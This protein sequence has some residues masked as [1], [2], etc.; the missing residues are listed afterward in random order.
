[1]KRLIVSF[2]L[3]AHTL[4]I[5]A[6]VE[7]GQEKISAKV[8]DNMLIVTFHIPDGYHQV[9]EKALFFLEVSPV[10]GLQ[11]G[12][13]T[14]PDTFIK[15]TY[16]NEYRGETDLKK[17]IFLDKKP[18]A[19]KIKLTA[20]YQLCNNSGTCFM[21]QEM[22]LD[23]QV[24][25]SDLKNNP[26]TATPKNIAV[27]K[28]I[29]SVVKDQSETAGNTEDIGEIMPQYGLMYILLLAFAGGLI[30]NLMPCV[31][32]VLSIKMLN[33]IDHA[34]SDRKTIIKSSMIYT[35]G[36]LLSFLVLALLVIFFKASGEAVGW[37]FQFQNIYFVFF[38]FIIIWAFALSLFELFIIN[39]PGMQA[40]VKASSLHGCLG[41]FMS[42]IFAVVLATPCTAP[43]LGTAVGFAFKQPP[44]TIIIIMLAVGLGLAFPFILLGFFPSIMKIIP[45]PGNWMNA[46]RITMG[47]LLIATAVFL[48]KTL[49][50]IASPKQFFN[51]IWFTLIFSFALWIF[52]SFA[53]PQFSKR[54]QWGG[55][56]ISLLITI[57]AGFYLLN[58]SQ[59][60]GNTNDG[61]S[62]TQR[63]PSKGDWKTFSPELL[64]K[65]RKEGKTVFIDFSAE[66][67]MTCKSN[68]AIVL[69]S[70]SVKKA[71]AEH[72]V[73]ILYG[74]FTKKNPIILEWLKKYNK[75]GVPLYLLFK[76]G[77]DKAIVF[78]EIITRNMV[79]NALSK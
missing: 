71:F 21:P 52:G 33:I 70:K 73:E 36:V 48:L 78:P 39:I 10:K 60:N 44:L 34:H 57:F 62:I 9:T 68:E 12:P 2:L 59:D 42:G 20:H 27:E 56:I 46:F 64:A 16:C 26:Q 32:P 76:P 22:I 23:V 11:F 35:L 40:A 65:L 79:L 55:T 14:Y 50:F 43:M 1:M 17:E 51:I 5:Y 13:T 54:K 25:P 75:V 4:L 72:K 63:S 3:F 37:G 7:P 19:D 74:D 38:L 47:F 28:K 49:Y 66:W 45:K 15:G 30:L 69:K 24:S 31:L 67:C 58:F 6:S 18:T 8:T 53:K 29:I 61:S 77:K 41:T